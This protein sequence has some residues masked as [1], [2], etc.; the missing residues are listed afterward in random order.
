MLCRYLAVWGQDDG[1][2][3]RVLARRVW[4]NG[5][6]DGS[7]FELAT[8]ETSPDVA[9]ASESGLFLVTT[10][11]DDAVYGRAVRHP[12]GRLYRQPADRHGP[13]DGDVHATAPCR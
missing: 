6:M 7:A 11:D 10:D 13:I 3:C 1:E 2:T 8:D 4:G 5:Q 12:G 9:Y